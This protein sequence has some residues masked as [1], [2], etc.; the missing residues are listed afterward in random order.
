M[1][2]PPR[3]AERTLQKMTQK[4]VRCAKFG[5]ELPA[6]DPDSTE[7]GR[8]L[9]M[10]ALIAGP[11]MM[12]RVRDNISA[13]AMRRWN[14]HMIMVINEYRLDPTSDSANAVLAEHM[15]AFF[16]GERADIPNYVPPKP[17]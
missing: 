5:Q 9:R 2:P 12:A 1:I 10:V 7:G 8:W 11:E 3:A 14:D 16:F 17:G 6:I 13:D 15:E 4:L